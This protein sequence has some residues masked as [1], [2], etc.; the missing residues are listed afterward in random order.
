MRGQ[1][2]TEADLPLR[3]MGRGHEPGPAE[4]HLQ[5]Q[6]GGRSVVLTSSDCVS[7][8]GQPGASDRECWRLGGGRSGGRPGPHLLHRRP[9]PAAQVKQVPGDSLMP[10]STVNS[11]ISES[12]P[13]DPVKLGYMVIGQSLN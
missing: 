11:S 12:E 6:Q 10:Q 2:L 8:Q 1:S 13:C 3:E 7:L 4:V 9:A 5:G